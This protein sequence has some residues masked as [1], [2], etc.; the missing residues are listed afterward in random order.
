MAF[1]L[2]GSDFEPPVYKT[3]VTFWMPIDKLVDLP[4]S[5]FLD[6]PKSKQA[7]HFFTSSKPKMEGA[8]DLQIKL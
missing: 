4:G 5:R 2:R 6:P 1:G 7:M 8:M 3:V